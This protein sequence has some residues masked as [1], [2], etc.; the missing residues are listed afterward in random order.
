MGKVGQDAFAVIRDSS[1]KMNIM[2]FGRVVLTC[3]EHVIALEP[4]GR[5]LLGRTPSYPYEV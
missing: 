4:K 5:G 2:A 1:G 3:R